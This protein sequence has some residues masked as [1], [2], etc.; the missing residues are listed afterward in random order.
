MKRVRVIPFVPDGPAHGI[1]RSGT[2]D[3]VACAI[4]AQAVTYDRCRLGCG[5]IRHTPSGAGAPQIT[6]H[7]KGGGQSRRASGSMVCRLFD[8]LAISHA[9]TAQSRHERFNTACSAWPSSAAGARAPLPCCLSVLCGPP[10]HAAVKPSWQIEL[11]VPQNF[12]T[13]TENRPTHVSQRRLPGITMSQHARASSRRHQCTFMCSVSFGSVRVV[14]RGSPAGLTGGTT[15]SCPICSP[16]NGARG[17]P[18]LKQPM[19]KQASAY[20]M[21]RYEQGRRSESCESSR[22]PSLLASTFCA[23]SALRV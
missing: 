8:V 4:F 16:T 11:G 22:R 19:C 21:L 2:A 20:G 12:K 9:W 18:D 15:R 5:G 17:L 13:L 14:A 7:R 6:K 23:T 10:P 1:R 3:I